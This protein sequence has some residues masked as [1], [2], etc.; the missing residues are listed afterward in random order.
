MMIEKLTK[1]QTE[2]LS[3]YRDKWLK[4]GLSAEQ[5]ITDKDCQL[6]FKMIS[7]LV[8]E[9]GDEP[10]SG[11]I[12]CDSPIDMKNKSK[13][14]QFIYD[15]SFGNHDSGWISFYDY[16]ENVLDIKMSKEFH[17][18][19]ELSV[20]FNWMFV[21]PKNKIVYLC[22]K[23]VEIH[24]VNGLLHNENGPS[25]KYADGFSVYS[26]EGYRVTEQIVMRPETLT[27]K[28][29]HE[30]SNSDIQSIMID[31]FGWTRYLEETNCKLLDSRKNDIENTMEA[32]YN[33]EQFGK[34]LVCTC[35]TGRVFVKG[36]PPE[37][38]STCE[39]AQNW[40]S[41][42]QIKSRK[43]FKTVGRT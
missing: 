28:Q 33:T 27:I 32:L 5:N 38:A 42:Y 14:K 36:V 31:R 39:E 16:M 23:P 24:M 9:D 11:W 26:I 19:R 1:K 6:A 15:R 12:L 43:K 2:Q 41:G 4:N 29:I 17:Y 25:V 40:L 13:N 22:K 35:P 3:I 37:A 8:L 21:C 34:R 18:I 10:L 30:Q 20:K 7:E